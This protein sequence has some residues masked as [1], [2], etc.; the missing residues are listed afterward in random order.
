MISDWV[1]VGRAERI[2]YSD[3]HALAA[4]EL[5]AAHNVLLHL[6]KLGELLC[7]IWSE[8]TGSLAAKGMAWN[9]ELAYW[10]GYNRISL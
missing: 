2:A 8:L 7:K 3:L 10:H 9:S 4:N 6:D 1:V 5:H